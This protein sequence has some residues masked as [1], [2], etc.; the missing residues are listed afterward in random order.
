MSYYDA[1]RQLQMD[2]HNGVIDEYAYSQELTALEY[3]YG[4]QQTKADDNR[5]IST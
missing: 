4:E 2:L 5:G 3:A 1:R